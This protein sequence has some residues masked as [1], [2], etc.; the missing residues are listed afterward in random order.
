MMAKQRFAVVLRTEI[1][2]RKPAL[3][4]DHLV[5]RG[6]LSSIDRARFW[7]E[8]DIRRA[9]DEALL[10]TSRQALAL[11][12]LPAGRPLRLPEAWRRQWPHLVRGA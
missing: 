9:D 12:Q 8:F 7:C 10:V 5:V 3:L 6:R 1:D 11:V 2:Y 4:G